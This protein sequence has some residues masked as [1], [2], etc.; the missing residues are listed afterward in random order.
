VILDL[1][2]GNVVDG[3]CSTETV[4]GDFGEAK[5]LNLALTIGLSVRIKN[6]VNERIG[7]SLLQINHSL[8]CL[9]NRRLSVHSVRIVQIDIVN[10]EP[11]QACLAGRLGVFRSA[12]DGSLVG[13]IRLNLSRNTKF[14]GQEDIG[15]TLR[16]QLEPLAD[17]NL[18]V[19]VGI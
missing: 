15:T 11:L 12:V 2:G 17:E 4:P 1:D 16:V 7:Y 10:S 9:L 3:A 13:A 8:D 19:A 18:R 5:V 14:G 6:A